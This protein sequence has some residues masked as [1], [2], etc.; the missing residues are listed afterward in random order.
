MA[1]HLGTEVDD[2]V[3]D[4]RDDAPLLA[5]GA[6]MNGGLHELLLEVVVYTL[7]GSSPRRFAGVGSD[8]ARMLPIYRDAGSSD[9]P[10]REQHRSRL[11]SG[12]AHADARRA[13]WETD[14]SIAIA[15][16]RIDRVASRRHSLPAVPAL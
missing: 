3:D 14:P 11:L 5:A 16:H 13:T 2:E 9:A 12:P 7:T 1:A 10:G 4:R 6:G 8:P 15:A